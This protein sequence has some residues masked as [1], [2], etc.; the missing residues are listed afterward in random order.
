MKKMTRK[1]VLA[2]VLVIGSILVIAIGSSVMFRTSASYKDIFALSKYENVA[3]SDDG[4]KLYFPEK[5]GL[6]PYLEKAAV[7]IPGERVEIDVVFCGSGGSS[8]SASAG[9][10]V[11]RHFLLGETRYYF[12][13]DSLPC[14]EIVKSDGFAV[15]VTWSVSTVTDRH[16][17]YLFSAG[18]SEDRIEEAMRIFTTPFE[19]E[20]LYV[21]E[22]GEEILYF[23]KVAEFPKADTVEV[24]TASVEEFAGDASF[25]KLVGY[26]ILP[27]NAENVGSLCQ[28]VPED[29]GQGLKL[30]DLVYSF[31]T[32]VYADAERETDAD[33]APSLESER[34]QITLFFTDFENPLGTASLSGNSSAS[35]KYE[36][37]HIHKNSQILLE[38]N[39][40]SETNRADYLLFV[41]KDRTV[42]YAVAANVSR[43]YM[44][45]LVEMLI[46]KRSMPCGSEEEFK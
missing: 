14:G 5:E 36:E 8:E 13:S 33:N 29:G 35:P 25:E 10:Y 34:G 15:Q 16:K 43:E 18:L 30:H 26:V 24:E 1:E 37:S 40:S 32:P 23:N 3:E 9:S 39:R 4:W 7:P 12:Y 45:D 20:D 27:E 11:D 46:Y 17:S 44:A 6:V 22:L 42:M 21:Y 38:C 2:M 31:Q 41:S 19:D 28:Y